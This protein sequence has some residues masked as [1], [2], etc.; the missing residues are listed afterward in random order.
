MFTVP[1]HLPP[2]KGSYER[3]DGFLGLS[4]EEY[5]RFAI[6]LADALDKAHR[7]GVV[8]RDY[9][10]GNIMLTKLGPKITDY[11]LA[12]F[13]PAAQGGMD[14]SALPT[15]EKPLTEKGAILGTF[16]YMAPEQL[17]AKDTDARTDIFAFGAVLYEMLTGRRAFEGKSRASLIGPSGQSSRRTAR[18]SS[19]TVRERPTLAWRITILEQLYDTVQ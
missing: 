7:A 9:K 13:G 5:L 16:Q 19:A 8:H 15:A 4:G 10:P 1:Y 18:S 14:L 3:W 2:C 6:Q 12:K 11:G 17:E